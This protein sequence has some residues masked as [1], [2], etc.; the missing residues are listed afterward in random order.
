MHAY[1]DIRVYIE[2]V[3]MYGHISVLINSMVLV[4]ICHNF[5]VL[6]PREYGFMKVVS[7][8]GSSVH[9]SEWEQ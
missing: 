6:L 8:S 2:G 9:P 7:G 1:T 4:P 3:H 5:M